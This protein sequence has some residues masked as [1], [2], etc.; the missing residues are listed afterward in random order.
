M[1]CQTMI[2]DMLQQIGKVEHEGALQ[3]EAN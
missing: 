1:A 2:F 3:H